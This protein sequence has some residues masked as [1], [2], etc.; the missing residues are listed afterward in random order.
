MRFIFAFLLFGVC[1]KVQS[2]ELFV[3]SEPASNM[4]A[5]SM[6]FRLNNNLMKESGT[7]HYN[8]HLIPEVMAGISKHI[9]IHGEAFISNRNKSLVAE[10]AALY[11]KYR[12][13]SQDEV[14]SHFRLAATVKGS[15]NNSD[16]HQEAIDLNGHNSGIET[17]LIATKLLNKVALST[18]ATYVYAADNS[19]GNKFVY[20]TENRHALG[21]NFSVGKLMLPKEY[22]SY[23][24]TNLN[25]MLEFLGQ[26]NLNTGKSF[27]DIAP[28]V[29]LIFHSRVRV[30]LGY[31]Y[32]LVKD[33]QRSSPSGG[34][35]RF[36]YN[37]YNIF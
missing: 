32:A 13:Y 11:L 3:Y 20:G 6:G 12:F 15:F 26:T 10:G 37:I 7:S 28:S 21:Y 25:L 4:A 33:L 2:Q 5:K 1:T 29:Q 8:Y 30:D 24:Q 23:K 31:R 34:L 16:I 17:G 19:N 14:H 9:M 27:L 18:G 36:E 35:L 22:S